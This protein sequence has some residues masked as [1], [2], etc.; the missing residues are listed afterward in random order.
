MLCCYE[1]LH[2]IN[3]YIHLHYR[4]YHRHCQQK[5]LSCM[6]DMIHYLDLLNFMVLLLIASAAHIPKTTIKSWKSI[7]VNSIAWYV[8]ERYCR[9][10]H[11]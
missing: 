9:E 11:V 8:D 2:H 6:L 1:Q 7:A 3:L 5:D 10:V 4:P